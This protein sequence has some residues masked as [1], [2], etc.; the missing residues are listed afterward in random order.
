MK[1]QQLDVDE[2]LLCWIRAFLTN[3]RQAVT[4]GGNMY[5]CKA[6]NGGV[7]QGMKLGVILFSVMTNRL[8]PTGRYTSSSLMTQSAIEILP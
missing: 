6:F 8:L 2:A 5:D 3:R 1:L 7:P 4:I